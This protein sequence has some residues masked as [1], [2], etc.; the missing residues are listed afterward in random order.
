[1]INK[2]RGSAA[3]PRQ[4]LPCPDTR[5]HVLLLRGCSAALPRTDA[6]VSALCR[7]GRGK[8][9]DRGRRQMRE[10]EAEG[11]E[12]GDVKQDQPVID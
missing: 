3:A 8:T 11:E 1:M 5:F 2:T 6:S 9:L 7:T 12:R 10:R 4:L